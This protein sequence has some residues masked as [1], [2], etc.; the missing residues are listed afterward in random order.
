MRD[1]RSG[2]DAYMTNV[3][4]EFPDCSRNEEYTIVF[5]RR[6]IVFPEIYSDSSKARICTNWDFF[7]ISTAG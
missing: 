7:P 6:R 3:R 1:K 2:D 4:Q 5:F